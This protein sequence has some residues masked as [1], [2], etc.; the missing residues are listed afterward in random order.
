MQD[1]VKYIKL[2]K[3][4]VYVIIVTIVTTLLGLIQLPIITKWLGTDLYGTWSL[5]NVTISLIVSFASLALSITVIR[6]LAAEKDI[7]KVR[8]D[9]L[10]ACCVTVISCGIFTILLFCFSDLLATNVF[11][12]AGISGYIKLA[13][14][15]ILLNALHLLPLAFFRMRGQIGLYSI[16]YLIYQVLQFILIVTALLL[17]YSLTGVIIA[18]IATGI[19]FNV[20]TLFIIFKKIGIQL[21]RFTHMKSYIRWGLPLTP[22]LAMLWIMSASDRYIVNYFLG[23]SAAGVYSASYAI[24]Q[25][26]YFFLMPIGI[27]L[28]PAI[29]KSYEAGKISDT[30][31]YLRLS[32]KYFMML[33][34]PSAFGLSILA[35]PLLR[36]LTTTDFVTGSIVIPLIAFSTIF[37]GIYQYMLY[38]IR[39]L[40]KNPLEPILLGI[41]AVLNIVL[42]II[43]I[44][45]MGI[46][47]A[48]L[49]TLI[50]YAV[51]GIMT[52]II[53]RR[54]LKY[55]LSISFIIKS[56]IASAFMTLLIWLLN[57]QSVA[58]VMISII[59]GAII[60]FAVLFL[61]RGFNRNEIT[62]FAHFI[63]DNLAKLKV[64]K[65]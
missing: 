5:I 9:F 10:S 61:I 45:I 57:P 44:P 48:A 49:A 11:K 39:I 43:L 17:G 59:G 13:S 7:N 12:D 51:L 3:Q 6:F 32:L 14:I 35:K 31:N 15:L 29:I 36:I 23:L 2:G 33:A 26:A 37:F 27:V 55:D 65:E 34:I 63:K 16:F 54:Y 8:E 62:F 25:Y 60:Y 41:S 42:N 19:I 24:G 47:G 21:P 30:K 58:L 52:A 22:N 20:V 56:I 46:A 4:V 38:V 50:A 64:S 1:N 18:F 53:T 28:Y 40:N